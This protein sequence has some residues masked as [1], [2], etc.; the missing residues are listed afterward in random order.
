[1]AKWRF[2]K[3]CTYLLVW[4]S[5]IWSP[6]RC[7]LGD[8]VSSQVVSSPNSNSN[9]RNSQAFS[10]TQK[11]LMQSFYERYTNLHDSDFENFMSQKVTSSL[12][13]VLPDNHNFRLRLSDLKRNLIGEG[14]HRCV[15]TSIKFQP[16]QSKYLSEIVSYSC[17]FIIIERLPSGVFADLFE[18]QHLVQRGVF[19]DIAV[20]GDTNLELPSF[21][22]NRSAVEIHLNVDPNILLEPTD[23]NIELPLHARYQ[24]LNESGYTPVEFGAPDMLVH[25]STLEKLENRNCLFKLEKDD[26]NLYDTRIVWRI[27]SGKMAHADLVSAVT[28]ISA[29][30]STLV[31]VVVSLYY[32][33]SRLNKYLKQS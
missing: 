5:F 32:S 3:L 12:C 15:D 19:S 21:L 33:S 10:L 18:L 7:L 27:A 30:L 6:G 9:I 23:I 24:P 16:Q 2:I 8:S 22:S 29:L 13:E 26:A 20:F 31:I 25:C 17:E 28:F 11:F 14:S 4:S 1:M